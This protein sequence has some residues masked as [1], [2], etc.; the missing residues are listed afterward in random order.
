MFWAGSSA[1][2]ASLGVQREQNTNPEQTEM[3]LVNCNAWCSAGLD[4]ICSPDVPSGDKGGDHKMNPQLQSKLGVTGRGSAKETAEASA[5]RAGWGVAL[6]TALQNCNF[7]RIMDI[8][9]DL[10]G[11]L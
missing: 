3:R 7:H 5:A 8:P 4:W 6:K 2:S 9:W 11:H 1:R 10:Q